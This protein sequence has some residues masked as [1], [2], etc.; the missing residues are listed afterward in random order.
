MV[1]ESEPLCR[2]RNKN[3]RRERK[4]EATGACELP[5]G[6]PMREILGGTCRWNAGWP[7]V[8]RGHAGGA[9][10]DF[11]V[12]QHLDVKMDFESLQKAGSRLGTGQ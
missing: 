3:F 1:Q 7:E 6:T 5:M 9:S 12:E 8:P 4:G 10:T 11:L 2:R